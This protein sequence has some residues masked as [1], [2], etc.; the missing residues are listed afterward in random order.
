MTSGS[1]VPRA[2][3]T[4]RS[5][6]EIEIF[7]PVVD[8]AERKRPVDDLGVSKRRGV[9]FSVDNGVGAALRFHKPKSP[10]RLI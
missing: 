10:V 2:F 8:V 3:S 6:A 9:A 7:L 5:G 1:S 4:F